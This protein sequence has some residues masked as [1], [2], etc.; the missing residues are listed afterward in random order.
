MQMD[1][2]KEVAALRLDRKLLKRHALDLCL[3]LQKNEEALQ[4]ALK[5]AVEAEESIAILRQTTASACQAASQKNV[6][7]EAVQDET[8]VLE[9]SISLLIDRENKL[10]AECDKELVA[11]SQRA[12]KQKAD[13]HA[14][15]EN[16]QF[17]YSSLSRLHITVGTQYDETLMV[18]MREGE[19]RGNVNDISFIFA[20]T[21]ILSSLYVSAL[22]KNILIFIPP[23]L[24]ILSA[25]GDLPSHKGAAFARIERTLW[26]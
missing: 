11:M 6:E 7:L 5:R 18:P 2:Q 15:T 19:E 21:S 20:P 25:P 3:K 13:A 22:I 12:E 4:A 16:V 10:K 17:C 1:Y 26:C 8:A 14:Q 9:K 23:F 24:H